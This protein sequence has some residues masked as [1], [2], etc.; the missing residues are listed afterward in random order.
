[1]LAALRRKI[2]LLF[3]KDLRNRLIYLIG[4]RRSGIRSDLLSDNLA[5]GASDNQNAALL[6]LGNFN[7]FPDGIRRLFANYFFHDI[8]PFRSIR[9]FLTVYSHPLWE[10]DEI[11]FYASLFYVNYYH[12]QL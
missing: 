1:M 4:N 2:N 12:C 8:S 6:K 5:C 11:S 10:N 3:G 9:P 7:Q